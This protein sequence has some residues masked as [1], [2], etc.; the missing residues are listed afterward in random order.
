[1][2]LMQK[3]KNFLKTC[4][5]EQ[6]PAEL[7]HALGT[8]FGESKRMDSN[9]VQASG[10]LIPNTSNGVQQSL[11]NTIAGMKHAGT[12]S[13]TGG[14]KFGDSPMDPK[15][16]DQPLVLPGDDFIAPQPVLP[17]YRD[18]HTVTSP[19]PQLIDISLLKSIDDKLSII[20]DLLTKKKNASKPRKRKP[21]KVP[22]ES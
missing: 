15:F 2:S 12:P 19:I 17:T 1:M 13:G 8:L 22:T 21:R 7:L 4:N 16:G 3:S 14:P 6:P 18:Q 10:N 11:Q 5:M 9:I 20:I